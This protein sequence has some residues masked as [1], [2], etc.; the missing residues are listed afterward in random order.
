MSTKNSQD[1]IIR[2]LERLD[3]AA[4]SHAARMAGLE[5]EQEELKAALAA[6]KTAKAR[7]DLL[8]AQKQAATQEL[9]DAVERGID[10]AI[11]LRSVARGRI[12]PRSE[13]LV[14]FRMPPL[15]RRS[16]RG[17]TKKKEAAGGPAGVQPVIPEPPTEPA[18]A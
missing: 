16:K 15:R 3:E 6:I 18:A 10:A 8:T 14:Q 11:V 2:D 7:Q 17:A 4:A 9:V 1:S 12:G 5:P 13:M